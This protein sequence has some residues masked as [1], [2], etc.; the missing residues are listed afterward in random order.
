MTSVVMSRCAFAA[1]STNGWNGRDGFGLFGG[2]N[3]SVL[4]RRT[5]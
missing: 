2:G 1:A 4:T 3:K 5:N